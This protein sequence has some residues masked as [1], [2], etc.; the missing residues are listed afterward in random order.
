M[1]G[2]SWKLSP[3]RPAG[4]NYFLSIQGPF[5]VVMDRQ[6]FVSSH[7]QRVYQYLWRHIRK[8]DL[9]HFSYTGDVEDNPADCL[10]IIL[11]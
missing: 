7:Y 9:D 10:K 8:S 4:T 6:E 2:L 11:Q 5:K 3:L 1:L